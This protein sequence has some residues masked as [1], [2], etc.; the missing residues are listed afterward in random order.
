MKG[1]FLR[2]WKGALAHKRTEESPLLPLDLQF[3]LLHGV[4]VITKKPKHKREPSEK[5]LK[6]RWLYR[7]IEEMWFNLTPGQLVLWKRFYWY[8]RARGWTVKK[9]HKR[10]RRGEVK[11]T[12]KNMGYRAFFFHRALSWKLEDWL[13]L[14]LKAMW[15]VSSIT[16]TESSFIVKAYITG[17]P[18]VERPPEPREYKEIRFRL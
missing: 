12:K 7:Q 14:W 1:K 16:Q 10:T 9:A 8:A 17:R 3:R 6:Q 2:A 5:Q 15:R 11:E 13:Y 4:S 18:D